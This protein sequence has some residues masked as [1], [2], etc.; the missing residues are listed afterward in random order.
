MFT[1]DSV[2]KAFQYI[3]GAGFVKDKFPE[4]IGY[5]LMDAGSILLNHSPV[6]CKD[7]CHALNRIVAARQLG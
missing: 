5:P 1:Q 7:K 3:D 2:F 6:I 4:R